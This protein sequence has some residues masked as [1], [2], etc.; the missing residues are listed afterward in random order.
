MQKSSGDEVSKQV[1]LLWLQGAF[2][3]LLSREDAL[4]WLLA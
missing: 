1:Y 4:V 3:R 2:S